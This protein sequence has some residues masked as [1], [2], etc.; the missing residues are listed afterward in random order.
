MRRLI[1]GIL[2]AL[3]TSATTWAAPAWNKARTIRQAD[4]TL[5]TIRQY[6]DEHH[7]WTETADGTLVIPT[8][9]GYFVAEIDDRGELVASDVLAHETNLRSIEEQLLVASQA[10]RRSLF[11]QEHQTAARQAMSISTTGDYL[12]HSG[13]PRVLT[14]LAAFQDKDFTVIEP[15]KAFEQYLNG[16]TLENLGNH[17]HLL[18]ASVNQYFNKCSHGVFTPQFD[19]VGP[20]TLPHNLSFYGSGGEKFS[21]FCKDAFEQA[22]DLVEDWSIYDNDNNG[23]AELVCIIYAG[24]GENQG[25]EEETI[26]AKASKIN[27]EVNKHLTIARFNCSPELLH[28]K[29]PGYINGTGVFIHE[30][31]HCMGLPDIYQT[32]KDYVNNQTMQSWDIMDVGCYNYN[33]GYAPA[34]YT[35]WEQEV[36]GWA[37]IETISSPTQI[38]NLTPLEEGGTA[39]KIVNSYDDNE[40]IVLENIQ[41]RGLNAKA[42]GKGLLVYH[43]AYPNSIINMS[44]SP[45]NII[46]RPAVAV[47]PAGGTLISYYLKGEGKQYTETEWRTSMAEAPFPGAKNV[48]DLT[49]EQELPN[50]VFYSGDASAPLFYRAASTGSTFS[51]GFSLHNITDNSDGSIAFDIVDNSTDGISDIRR[52]SLDSTAPYFDL[53]G[54][55]ISSQPSRGLYIKDG[56]KVLIK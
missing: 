44:D 41:Q 8:L 10:P 20:V 11:H 27:Q 23:V 35:A 22:K 53:Q 34:A 3:L 55:R 52:E 6:G 16:E 38:T 54:R 31:S 2:L 32:T 29:A 40:F 47:V 46:G 26:W 51:V 15:K 21:T 1:N 43:I 14:I 42:Y 36:M 12:P 28:P 30:M 37:Q 13:S 4:G 18:N 9:K 48:T 45:N 49:D 7:H 19:V 39:Y 33:G 50:Y 24:Y 56:K 5:L 25:G 17:N